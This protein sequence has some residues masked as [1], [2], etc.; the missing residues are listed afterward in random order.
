M[1]AGGIEHAEANYGGFLLSPSVRIGTD[2]A[3][4]S[5]TLTPSLR[6]RYAGLFLEGY[7]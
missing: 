1:V 7:E 3:M 5:G 6:L 4:G 2:M